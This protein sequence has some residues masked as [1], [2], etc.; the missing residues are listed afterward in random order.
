MSMSFDILNAMHDLNFDL[1]YEPNDKS[2]EQ[3]LRIV[4][5]CVAM[6]NAEAGPSGKKSHSTS[7]QERIDRSFH[8]NWC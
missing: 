6:E 7:P 5:L 3:A 2:E 1:T 8:R 4:R